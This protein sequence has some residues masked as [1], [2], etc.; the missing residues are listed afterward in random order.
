MRKPERAEIATETIL[1]M[2]MG[3]RG[4]TPQWTIRTDR[5]QAL[6]KA[7]YNSGLPIIKVEN[8]DR[9]FLVY[10]QTDEQAAKMFRM[11]GSW[12]RT[13]WFK[14]KILKYLASAPREMEPP[15]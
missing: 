5:T 9:T 10:V 14:K 11:L 7:I 1:L 12:P 8:T 3:M 6:Y 4:D 2:V 15:V 13:F